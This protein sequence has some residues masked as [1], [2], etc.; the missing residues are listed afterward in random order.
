ME[1]ILAS[2]SPRRRDLLG[3]LGWN[4]RVIVPETDERALP[5][6]SP[7]NLCVRLS[8]AKAAK[9]A[10]MI[11]CNENVPIV[12]ADTI[13]VVDG[14][15]LG[16]PADE[17]EG[18]LMLKRLQGRAHEVLTGVSVIGKGR[19]FSGMERTRVNFRTLDDEAARAYAATG[20]GADKAGGY[21]IQGKGS[22]LA[23]SIEGD[24]FNVV[25]LPLCRL[26]F[27]IE[28]MGLNLPLQWG[29]RI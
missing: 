25:G 24:Y 23:A 10:G 9:A 5:G 11:P 2:G 28:E 16:K 21:A 29:A 14:D 19:T 15:V 3:K 27:M 4:V 17:D 20:E 18:F 12:G 8:A 13:V 26:S 1:I 22:L 6:E 7:E